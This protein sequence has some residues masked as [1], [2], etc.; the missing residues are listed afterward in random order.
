M[1]TTLTATSLAD[2]LKA[3]TRDLR[4]A[5]FCVRNNV[6]KCCPGCLGPEDFPSWKEDE[7]QPLLYTFGGQGRSVYVWQD[8]ATDKND[9]D[10]DKNYIY[11][12]NLTAE[13]WETAKAI[14][15]KHGISVEWDGNSYSSVILDYQ[16][17]KAASWVKKVNDDIAARLDAA[18]QEV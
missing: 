10:I 3:A 14:Y 5:G 8:Y 15:E 6:K 2:R 12:T 17:S 18:R 13:A 16:K 7:N 4:H 9:R 1:T 11:H